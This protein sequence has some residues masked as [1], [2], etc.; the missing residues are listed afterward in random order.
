MKP[1][2]AV[3]LYLEAWNVADDGERLELVRRAFTSDADRFGRDVA[4]GPA[5]I[6][7][8][9]FQI[10]VQRTS[11]VEVQGDWLRFEWAAVTDGE[12]LEGVDV[13]EH[14]ADGRLR[15]LIV[16]YTLRAPAE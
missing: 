13:A 9:M 4:H 3:D 6:A 14:V 1:E 10:E 2:D 8:T 12:Q 11:A 5:A 16:F 15:R 7:A